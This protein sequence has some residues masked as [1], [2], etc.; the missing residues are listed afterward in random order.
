MFKFPNMFPKA[1]R[2]NNPIVK[3]FNREQDMPTLME[4]KQRYGTDRGI[5]VTSDP[6]I[7]LARRKT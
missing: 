3:D 7:L 6:L 5:C 2:S 1:R 4:L